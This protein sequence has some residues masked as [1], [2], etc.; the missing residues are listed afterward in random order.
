[1]QDG[2]GSMTASQRAYCW[3]KERILSGVAAGGNLLSEGEVAQ[4][5]GLSRTP[6]REAFLRLEVE[7]LLQLYPKRGALV[8][9]V[10]VQEV[11]DV[12][13]A[14]LLIERFAADKVIASGTHVQ[15]AQ[16]MR[17]VLS[18]QQRIAASARGDALSELD[19]QFHG[20]LVE[21]AGN[22]IVTSLYQT[23]RDRQLRISTMMFERDPARRPLI[24]AEHER[25]C[26]HLAAADAVALSTGINAHIHGVGEQVVG[27][28]REPASG[29]GH[30]GNAPQQWF[31]RATDRRG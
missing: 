7:G 13:E 12:L 15:V 30:D 21:A 1:M 25:L 29:T 28:Q 11:T 26:E 16:V 23:L 22:A 9:P 27:T 8:V 2:Q 10:S 17:D 19:R 24:L 31:R 3:T 18:Q 4:A 6:V 5:L 20:T 14:R